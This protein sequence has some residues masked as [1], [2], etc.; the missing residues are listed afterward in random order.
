MD[1]NL[2]PDEAIEKPWFEAGS[3]YPECC[4]GSKE[5]CHYSG[6]EATR[7]A[8]SFVLLRPRLHLRRKV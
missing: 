3:F 7:R 2:S 4:P 8:T 1:T 6:E 5:R